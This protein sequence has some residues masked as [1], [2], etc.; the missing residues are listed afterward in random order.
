MRVAW[1]SVS[2]GDENG[3]DCILK[4][5][6]KQYFLTDWVWHVREREES[7]MRKICSNIFQLVV[8]QRPH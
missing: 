7:R 3:L 5:E 2:W 4:T 8:N 1:S 6:R